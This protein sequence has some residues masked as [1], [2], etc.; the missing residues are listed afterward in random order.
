MSDKHPKCLHGRNLYLC[1]DCGGDGICK[2]EKQKAYCN[3]CDGSQICVHG[4]QRDRCKDCGGRR[5]NNSERMLK[6]R[7][8]L[9]ETDYQEI[10]AKQSGVCALCGRSAK[11]L[12]VDHDHK[13]C[14]KKCKS[15]GKCIRGL[16]CVRCNMV[17]GWLEF[18][19]SIIQKVAGYV[20]FRVSLRHVRVGH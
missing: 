4:K 7:Y 5:W 14:P 6:T 1:K 19:P 11:R 13:C 18:N 9:T 16:L 10:L 15:C 17:L 20:D 12:C 3:E 2:H 8:G